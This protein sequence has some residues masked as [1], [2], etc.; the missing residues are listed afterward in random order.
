MNYVCVYKTHC[1]VSYGWWR[2]YTEKYSFQIKK[3]LSNLL[4]S[5]FEVKSFF[6]TILNI[7][8]TEIMANHG[9]S[10]VLKVS[11]LLSSS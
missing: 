11:A 1:K 8:Q 3:I 4:K 7:I 2:Q 9:I 10:V 5:R 6:H